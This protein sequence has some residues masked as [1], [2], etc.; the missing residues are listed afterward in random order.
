[1]ARF[2]LEELISKLKARGLYEGMEVDEGG[3]S[4]VEEYEVKVEE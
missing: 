4:I 1:M 3:K 2:Q